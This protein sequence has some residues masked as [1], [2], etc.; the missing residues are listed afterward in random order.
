MNF[1]NGK[2]LFAVIQQKKKKTPEIP[3]DALSQLGEYWLIHHNKDT[4]ENGE[5]KDHFH[6]LIKAYKG[7][8]STNWI[9]TLADLFQVEEDAIS[10]ELMGSEQACMLYMLHSTEDSQ[11]V[12]GNAIY[13]VD[14]VVTNSKAEFE[15]LTKKRLVTDEAILA[16]KSPQEL[17][18]LVGW[19]KYTKAQNTV[20]LYYARVREYDQKAMEIDFLHQQLCDIVHELTLAKSRLYEAEDLIRDENRDLA[21][22]ERVQG[23]KA[24]VEGVIGK[25][26]H[27][28]K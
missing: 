10:V 2:N 20:D 18:A 1:N 13:S 6:L 24:S 15:R 12:D 21:L 8:S 7:K 23:A 28:E 16:C 17:Y 14:D 3:S 27:S 4:D 26:I 22:L 25:I 11:K 19:E 5:K 9:K